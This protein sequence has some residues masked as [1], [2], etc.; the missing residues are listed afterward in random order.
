MRLPATIW[1]GAVE[2]RPPGPAS[3]MVTLTASP[4]PM[5]SAGGGPPCRAYAAEI[6]EG[7]DRQG[8][9]NRIGDLDQHVIE[10]D[11]V[12]RCGG[13]ID[14]IGQQGPSAGIDEHAA[15]RHPSAVTQTSVP[16]CRHRTRAFPLYRLYVLC[17]GGSILQV[18][19]GAL[20]TN[21]LRYGHRALR[22]DRGRS[23][24]L[25]RRAFLAISDIQP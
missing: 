15:V 14:H 22:N 18:E 9:D 20:G 25:I 19:V 7:T 5:V 11:R 23:V 16:Y 4:T 10:I 17:R 1:L 24:W 8:I 21:V 13:P 12:G 3:Q 2:N 6:S